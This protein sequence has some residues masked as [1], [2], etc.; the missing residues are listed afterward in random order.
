MQSDSWYVSLIEP[1]PN[2][3]ERRGGIVDTIVLHY[4][5]MESGP[6]ALAR[7]CD[8]A[9]KVS[10]HYL[11]HEDGR[12]VQLVAESRRAY[13]AGVSSWHGETDINSRSIGIEIV[14]G[15]HDFGLPDFPEGQIGAVIS[16]CQDIQGRWPVKPDHVLAHSDVAPGRKR[17]PG[18]KFPWRRLFDAGV[19]LWVEP[20][21]VSQ[22]AVLQQGDQNDHVRTLKAELS[23]YGYGVS[24]TDVYDESLADVV[25]AFQLHFRPRLVDGIADVSTRQTLSLLSRCRKAL[26]SS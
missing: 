15:G 24:E 6:A 7:L 5:G 12:I 14:N 23:S 26:A 3:E 2:H 21:P 10:S 22:G 17:D 20:A 1:S 13:H 19:G 4:T 9:A 18:E 25:S 16:L 11:V 8:P